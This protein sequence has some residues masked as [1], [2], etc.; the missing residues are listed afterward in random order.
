MDS[1]RSEYTCAALALT[2][3]A[4]G[5]IG[6]AFGLLLP[7]SPIKFLDALNFFS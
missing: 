7:P 2:L 1:T 5:L 6:V 3:V 4:G